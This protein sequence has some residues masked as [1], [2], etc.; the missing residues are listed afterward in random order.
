MIGRKSGDRN[1]LIVSGTAVLDFDVE[2]SITLIG[3][4]NLGFEWVS[5]W[6]GSPGSIKTSWK[7][8]GSSGVLA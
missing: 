6:D 2:F 3:V 4:L 7:I 5:S 1:Y 8:L